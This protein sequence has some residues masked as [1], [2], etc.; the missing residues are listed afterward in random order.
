MYSHLHLR[1]LGS[2]GALTVVAVLTV[3]SAAYAPFLGLRFAPGLTFR[4]LG[5]DTIVAGASAA[6]TWDTSPG[7]QRRYPSEKIE[8]CQGKLFGVRCV[9][10]TPDTPND[11][12]A[13]VL[14]PATLKSGTWYLRLTAR[15]SAR[16]L[17]P[18]RTALK[19]V[20]VL[21]GVSAASGK[22]LS[23]RGSAKPAT[24][25]SG[26]PYSSSTDSTGGG[27]TGGGVGVGPTGPA[28]RAPSEIPLDRD[29]RETRDAP[30][31]TPPP[32][33]TASA[34]ACYV[35]D[36]PSA[37]TA[38]L[39]GS[40]HGTRAYPATCSDVT[41]KVCAPPHPFVEFRGGDLK[42]WTQGSCVAPPMAF[43]RASGVDY[44][45]PGVAAE[46][47]LVNIESLQS[48]GVSLPFSCGSKKPVLGPREVVLT[49]PPGC[50]GPSHA[51]EV[52]SSWIVICFGIW[53]C[54]K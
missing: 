1:A 42:W 33:G 29:G 30:S 15:S 52:Q 14:I 41:E 10:L 35:G 3:L 23:Q 38:P 25:P 50:Y 37:G 20:R 16:K 9:T 36:V 12:E 45:S 44:S 39:T 24:P 27:E 22:K 47:C 40:Y 17:S 7:N 8:L 53:H 6:I 13:R 51:C 49:I 18:R 43:V 54:G 28:P 11:G 31:P 21:A 5:P 32:G 4:I 19:R 2:L 34:G 46:R 48:G 26:S